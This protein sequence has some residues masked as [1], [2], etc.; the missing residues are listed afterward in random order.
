MSCIPEQIAERF[1]QAERLWLFLDYDGTLADFAPTPE[2][3]NPAPEIIDL[4][5]RLA[6]HPCIRIAVISGRR[7]DHVRALVPVPGILLA[8]TYGVELQMPEGERM[9]R[10]EYDAIRPA[11][12][13]LKPRWAHLI[14]GREG[15]FLEDK[16]WALALHARFANDVETETVLPTARCMATEVTPSELFRVLSGH[17]FLEVCPR[18]A[19][20]GR[21]VDYLLDRYPW[22]G[23]LPLYLGDD[24]KDEEAFGVI[25]ARGGITI[26]VAA[27]PRNTKADC[28]LES[29]QAARQWLET[30]L[31]RLGE[32]APCAN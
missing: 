14:A 8:G 31:T 25:K 3:V 7:L 23:A 19:H 2:H 21:T 32:Q 17:K 1:A 6:R 11:L 26:L 5:T 9:S 28:R 12:D 24:D 4:L 18:L 15:F 16:G 27:E 22:P 30:L 20:K 13:I 29:P 10:V